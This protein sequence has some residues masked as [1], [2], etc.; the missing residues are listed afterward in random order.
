MTADPLVQLDNVTRIYDTGAERITAIDNLTL[1]LHRR[2][3]TAIAG[4]SGSGKTTLLN[5][6]AGLDEPTRGSVTFDGISLA[7]LST[8][9]RRQL[10]LARIGFVFQSFGLLPY[11]TAAE[12]TGVPLRVNRL[13]VM[14]REQRIF[15]V[16]DAV[17][18]AHRQQHLPHE[19]SGGERQRVAIARALVTQPDLIIADEPTGQLDSVTG[20]RI[21]DLLYRLID[22]QQVTVV[23]VSHDPQVIDQA[24]TV[25]HLTSGRLSRYV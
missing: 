1:A 11:L 2:E 13:A 16:L 21:I 25:H 17:G 20:Q 4:P 8:P 9:D 18:M 7:A 19:L 24:Q 10:R 6:I 22:R 14:E 15:D 23:V 5:L 3:F 12:N